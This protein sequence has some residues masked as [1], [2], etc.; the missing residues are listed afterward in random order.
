L[1]KLLKMAAQARDLQS[2]PLLSEEAASKAKLKS[3]FRVGAAVF[4]VSNGAFLFGYHLAVINGPLQSI[5]REFGVAE[6]PNL[7]GTIVSST[8]AGGAVGSLGGSGIADAIGRRKSFLV[9]CIPLALGAALASA[10]GSYAAIVAGRFLSGIGIGLSSA[11]VPV[12]ISEVSPTELRGL[13]GSCNQLSIVI[14]ALVALVANMALS[15]ARWRCSMALALAPTA[16]L[17]LGMCF[18]CPESPRWLIHHGRRDQALASAEWLWGTGSAPVFEGMVDQPGVSTA[19]VSFWGMFSRAN[20]RVAMIAVALFFLQQHAGVNALLY[21]STSIFLKAGLPSGTTA[22]VLVFLF[23]VVGTVVSGYLVDCL[24]RK[25]LL[26]GSF[27]GMGVSMAVMATCMAIPSLKG[28]SG[29]V[30]VVGTLTYIMSFALGAGPIPMLLIPEISPHQIRGKHG[31]VRAKK[32]SALPLR[33]RDRIFCLKP[34][35][36]HRSLRR[37]PSTL[38]HSSRASAPRPTRSVCQTLQETKRVTGRRVEG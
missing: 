4:L 17:F 35:L 25:Q 30:A 27:T 16:L 37:R 10:A 5:G 31:T 12:Y 24:G 14:G 26:C 28:S 2:T 7:L 6:K 21:Y 22:S 11:L 15:A 8:L 13:L 19:K 29:P 9:C 32:A 23:N 1:L 3:I 20:R 36:A 38:L 18:V 33:K 34:G